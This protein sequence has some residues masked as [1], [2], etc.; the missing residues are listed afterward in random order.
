MLISSPSDP[1][2]VEGFSNCCLAPMTIEGGDEGTHYYV[3]S[4]CGEACD[5]KPSNN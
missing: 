4:R 5:K 3:C 2:F 1:Y